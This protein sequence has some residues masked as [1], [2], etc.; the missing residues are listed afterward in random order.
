MSAELINFNPK[1]IQKQ[2]VH[3]EDWGGKEWYETEM[4][5]VPDVND[6]LTDRKG[7]QYNVRARQWWETETGWIVRIYLKKSDP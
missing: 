6:F 7:I 3:I 1:P 4:Y 2:T 5:H